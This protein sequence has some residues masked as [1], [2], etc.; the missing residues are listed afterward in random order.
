MSNLIILHLDVQSEE[1]FGY[2]RNHF[3]GFVWL[4]FREGAVSC[5]G[6]AWQ[7]SG[8]LVIFTL[9]PSSSCEVLCL[10]SNIKGFWPFEGFL[11]SFY[12][13]ATVLLLLMTSTIS[14]ENK[15]IKRTLITLLKSRINT[16]NQKAFASNLCFTTAFL[17]GNVQNLCSLFLF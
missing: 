14:L 13:W 17:Y 15:Y 6:D 7:G 16:E 5:V 1:R 11:I 3:E 12:F 10:L 4:I 8:L 2:Y 9:P